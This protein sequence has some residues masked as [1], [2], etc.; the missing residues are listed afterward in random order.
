MVVTLFA[1]VKLVID[2]FLNESFLISTTVALALVKSF[3]TVDG[4]TSVPVSAW[5]SVRSTADS[6]AL[7]ELAV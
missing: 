4:I 2:R 7:P 5:P 3:V 6:V 1:T